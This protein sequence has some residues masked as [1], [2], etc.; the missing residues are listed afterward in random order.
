ETINLNDGTINGAVRTAGRLGN[1]LSFDGTDDNINVPDS[2]SLDITDVVTMEA[3]VKIDTYPTEWN[4]V[5][6]KGNYN[7]NRN[8]GMW[9]RNT[10]DILVSYLSGDWYSFYP[11]GQGFTTGVWH[12]L[13][14]I[15]D[16]TNN[17]RAIYIDGELKAEDDVTIIPSLTVNDN[18][19]YMGSVSGN[20]PFDGIIDE[21]SVY[22]KRL[23]ETEIR[24]RY[25]AWLKVAKASDTSGGGPGIQ[26]GNWVVISFDGETD[27]ANI[28]ALNIDTALAL[29]NGHSWK[30]GNN[31]IGSAAWSTSSYNNDTLTITLSTDGNIPD[32][33]VFDSITLDGTIKDR[34]GHSIIDSIFITGSFDNN[35]PA[36]AAGYWRFDAGFGS[37]AYDDTS[38]LIVGDITGATWTEGKSGNGLSFDGIDDSV[39]VAHNDSL[40]ITDELTI[41][42]WIKPAVTYD[43]SQPTHAVLM[44]RQRSAGTDSYFLGI[45]S[46]CKLHLGSYGGNIQSTKNIWEAGT[47][48]HI[49]GTYRD[50][51]GTY[52]GELY[53]NGVAE[54]LTV[55][56]YDNIGGGSQVIGI[57]GSNQFNGFNGVIDEVVIYNHA[58][59]NTE[60]QARYNLFP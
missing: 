41:E 10:G 11:A 46:D 40:N 7:T 21:V 35:L 30:D 23:A 43:S 14:G 4:L 45:N 53:V 36:G 22:N 1:A 48:Y 25:R 29:D 47:W 50:T 44:D 34:L 59:T 20:F 52:S 26:A 27:G 57:G 58:L 15:I 24:D 2:Q 18:P 6:F 56:N 3:W 9:V 39:V 42:I 8:Y 5:L 33:S 17:Y 38:N 16:T 55:D 32:V 28:D 13:V 19:L 49:V 12:H 51:G 60:V 31:S 54:T 37:T